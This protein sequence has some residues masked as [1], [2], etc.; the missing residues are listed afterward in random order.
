MKTFKPYTLSESNDALGFF[1]CIAYARCLVA[2]EE[3]SG[4]RL[5]AT[6]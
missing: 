3:L 1:A 4:V 5:E 6:R 2:N